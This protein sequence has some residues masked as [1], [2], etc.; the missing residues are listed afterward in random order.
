M[1]T[2]ILLCRLSYSPS[3]V[4]EDFVY[5]FLVLSPVVFNRRISIIPGTHSQDQNFLVFPLTFTIGQVHFLFI[6]LV[7]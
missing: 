1:T 7:F 2:G 5:S 3:R 6:C 4:F